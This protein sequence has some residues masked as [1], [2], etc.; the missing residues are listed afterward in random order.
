MRALY[1]FVIRS[2]YYRYAEASWYLEIV[3]VQAGT[4]DSKQNPWF[5]RSLPKL[6]VFQ[7]V[8]SVQRRENPL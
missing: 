6:R 7:P 2:S 4:N 1:Q 5:A 8:G 3:Q